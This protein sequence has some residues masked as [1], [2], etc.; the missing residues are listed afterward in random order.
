MSANGHPVSHSDT[1]ITSRI[2]ALIAIVLGVAVVSLSRAESIDTRRVG[3]LSMD[4]PAVHV[5]FAAA[6]REG[7][8]E[9]GYIEG[10]NVS[11]E[12]RFAAN[13]QTVLPHLVSELLGLKLDVLVADATQAALAAK[14]ATQ[15]VPIVVPTSG[16]LVRAGLVNSLAHP[17]GNL[18]GLTVMS[19]GL[20]GKRLAVLKEMAPH[21]QRVAVLVN[22]DNPSGGFQLKEAQAAAPKLG[23]KL[24]PISIRRPQ[25]IER[26]LPLY[27]GRVDS[28]LVTDDPVLDDFRT[29][30]GAYSIQNRLPSICSYRMP[31]DKTCLMWY[32]PDLVSMYKRA[33]HYVVRILNGTKPADLPVEQ[34]A[35]LTLVINAKTA[36]DIGIVIP[37]SLLLFADEVV[38]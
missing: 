27:T 6:F 16:D 10:K 18:T 28:I 22:P 2:A 15:T 3:Y 11:I 38:H 20:M 5:P 24:E 14:H 23:L 31:E 1:R 29:Q 17:G 26:V 8:R 13:D 37:Q 4:P 30:I 35:R 25:D 19:P 21:I 36:S 9:G 12:W 7:L 33:A 32:G 34:P